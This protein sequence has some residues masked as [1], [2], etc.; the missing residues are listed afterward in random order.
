MAPVGIRGGRD[1]SKPHARWHLLSPIR[2]KSQVALLTR[3]RRFFLVL[4]IDQN[5]GGGARQRQ[6]S[7]LQEDLGEATGQAHRELQTE[8]SE[9]DT[10]WGSPVVMT[11]EASG[12]SG[13]PCRNK[14]HHS[15]MLLGVSCPPVLGKSLVCLPHDVQVMGG[16]RGN[17]PQKGDRN[18]GGSTHTATEATCPQRPS[19]WTPCAGNGDM[20]GWETSV[21]G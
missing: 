2:R 10:A 19:C 6:E 9:G 12:A 21:R 20:I 15:M 13:A 18:S 11:R 8:R 17:L 14:H 16:G 7:T 1:L 5:R 4:G 3:M